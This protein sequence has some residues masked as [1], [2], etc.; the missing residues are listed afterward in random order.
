MNC[1][2]VHKKFSAFTLLELLVGMIV[3]GIV[4]T[5]TFSAYRIVSRQNL[6][7]SARS[8]SA[9]D[10]SFF[11]SRLA[12][13]FSAKGKVFQLTENEISIEQEKRILQY[14]FS[15]K[16]IFRSDGTHTDTFFVSAAAVKTFYENNEVAGENS[17]VDELRLSLITGEKKEEKTFTKP[18][19]AKNKMD[20]E[21]ISILQ[22]LK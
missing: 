15:E 12:A 13:D 6:D 9:T 4:L 17:E 14:R 18:Q 21:E 3:S 19:C 16:N 10:L 2:I 20:E 7:Y 8:K 5:A 1:S 22:E 11:V